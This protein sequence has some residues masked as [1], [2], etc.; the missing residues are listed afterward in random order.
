MFKAIKSQNGFSLVSVMIA[1]AAVALL[2]KAVLTLSKNTSKISS[3]ATQNSDINEAYNRVQK[4]LLN[5]DNCSETLASIP[6]VPVGSSGVDVDAIWVSGPSGSRIAKLTVGERVGQSSKVILDKIEFER[7]DADHAVFILDFDKSKP[8]S[9]S[10][11]I[12]RKRFEVAVDFDATQKPI[13]CFSQ[14]DNAVE[15]A[16]KSIDINATI[17]GTNC[18]LSD[19]FKQ[20][21]VNE[22]FTAA[23]RTEVFVNS[24]GGLSLSESVES[25]RVENT[26]CNAYPSYPSCPSGWTSVSTGR[27]RNSG[28]GD[29]CGFRKRKYSWRECKF[30]PPSL[31]NLYK[32]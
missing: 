31:G 24:S 32:L 28:I 11:R 23:K 15:T 19:S 10:K 2:S 9:T 30:T 16:C 13:K 26:R 8:G 1:V 6:S 18:I 20:G 17:S 3:E 12:I 4:Y 29:G 25:T 14:L 22:A 7:I 5:S 27:R 21:L